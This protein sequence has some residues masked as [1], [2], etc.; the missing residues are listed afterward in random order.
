MIVSCIDLFIKL[1]C[2]MSMKC[3][4]LML[5]VAVLLCMTGMLGLALVLLWL[6]W[7]N[8]L[9]HVYIYPMTLPCFLSIIIHRK[10][11]AQICMLYSCDIIIII[12]VCLILAKDNY[13]AMHFIN[14]YMYRYIYILWLYIIVCHDCVNCLKEH[15]PPS[16]L[17]NY[18]IA[19]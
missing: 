18:L 17:L 9:P 8:L 6:L 13:I 4:R 11:E 16:L 5:V 7:F 14:S 10:Q 15:P 2:M 1:H 19:Y 12:D 3:R